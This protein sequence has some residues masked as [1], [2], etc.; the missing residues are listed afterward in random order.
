MKLRNL[1]NENS[2]RLNTKHKK[3]VLEAI[4]N[5]NALVKVSIPK[6]TLRR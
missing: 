2:D 6:Q 1:L 4:A 5:F 3:E